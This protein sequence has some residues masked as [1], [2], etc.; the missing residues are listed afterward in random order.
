MIVFFVISLCSCSTLLFTTLYSELNTQEP[1]MLTFGDFCPQWAVLNAFVL[2][3][4]A[5]LKTIRFF[6]NGSLSGTYNL[7]NNNQIIKG[8][9]LNDNLSS[10]YFALDFEGIFRVY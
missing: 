1:S 9:F 10:R 5:D 3:P 4:T 6:K 7:E 8:H 2:T